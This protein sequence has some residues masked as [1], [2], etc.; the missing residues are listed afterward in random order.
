M[1]LYGDLLSDYDTTVR[2]I[3]NQSQPIQVTVGFSLLSINYFDEVLQKFSTTGHMVVT[4]TDELLRWNRD[5]YGGIQKFTYPQDG[6]WRPMVGLIT[7]VEK[8]KLV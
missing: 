6:V 2:P 5:D 4:W 7:P 8:F 3:L 1:R